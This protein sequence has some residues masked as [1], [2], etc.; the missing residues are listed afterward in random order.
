MFRFVARALAA[1]GLIVAG[2]VL[3][4]PAASA[5][6]SCYPVRGVSGGCLDN[7]TGFGLVVFVFNAQ[8]RTVLAHGVNATCGRLRGT[9]FGRTDFPDGTRYE[10]G[11]SGRNAIRFTVGGNRIGCSGESTFAAAVVTQETMNLLSWYGNANN[12]QRAQVVS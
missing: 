4:I 2:S 1:L 7:T 11:A 6:S 9:A 10:F 8:G 5:A 3:F 12:V